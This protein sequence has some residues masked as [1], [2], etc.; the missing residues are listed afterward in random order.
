LF[1]GKKKMTDKGKLQNVFEW[2]QTFCRSL[3]VIR[4]VVIS[5]AFIV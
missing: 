5:T 1:R 4:K 3:R 2:K